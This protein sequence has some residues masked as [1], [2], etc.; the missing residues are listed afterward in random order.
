[1]WPFTWPSHWVK[2][3]QRLPQNKVLTYLFRPIVGGYLNAAWGWRSN[4]WLV[5]I[6]IFVVW[7][8]IL[9]FLPE[10]WRPAPVL[11]GTPAPT[12]KDKLKQLNP[13]R[14]FKF[15][16]YPNISLSILFV[17]IVFMMFY[18]INTTFTRTYTIQYG[19]DSGTVGLCYLPL[20]AG[21]IVGTQIGGRYADKVYNKRVAEA[22]GNVYPEMRLSLELVGAAVVLQIIGFLMYGWCVQENVHY[23]AG[24]VAIFIC[25]AEQSHH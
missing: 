6:F 9:V 11:P 24:L 17:A 25:K 1:M 22:N 8:F 2:K 5:C 15:F 12:R 14:V 7:T 10:T 21:G 19:L 23:A 20:A 4:F 13:L 3:Q 18:F 16:L